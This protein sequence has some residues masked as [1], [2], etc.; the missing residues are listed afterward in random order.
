MWTYNKE[1]LL[2]DDAIY[3]VMFDAKQDG[4]FKVGMQ[5]ELTFFDKDGKK[6]GTREEHFNRKAWLDVKKYNLYTQCDAICYWYTEDTTYAEKSKIEMLHFLDDFCQGA[7]HWLRY[8][9]RPEGSDAYGGVQGGRILFTIAVAYSMIRDS[10]VEQGRKRAF[11]WT[12]FLYVALS[13]RLARPYPSDK[14]ACTA[15]A[16]TGRPICTLEQQPL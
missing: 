5:I 13:G 1:I 14:G 3:T 15:E 12:C 2:R 8:N 9:E 10:G 11:L 4:K 6:L 16:A 7:H